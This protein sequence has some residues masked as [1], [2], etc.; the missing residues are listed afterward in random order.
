MKFL[1]APYL[2]IRDEQGNIYRLKSSEKWHNLQILQEPSGKKA[3]VNSEGQS[4]EFEYSR[5]EYSD[6]YLIAY[7]TDRD[8]AYFHLYDTNGNAVKYEK[9]VGNKE[10][11]RGKVYEHVEKWF[12][13]TASDG[14]FFYIKNGKIEHLKKATFITAFDNLNTKFVAIIKL[15]FYG[16]V[17]FEGANP[18][19]DKLERNLKHMFPFETLLN[20]EYVKDYTV[21]IRRFCLGNGMVIKVIVMIN[22]EKRYITYFEVTKNDIYEKYQIHFS[23]ASFM[24]LKHEIVCDWYQDKPE[25]VLCD[26][27]KGKKVLYNLKQCKIL[28]ETQ[29]YA[30]G[31]EMKQYPYIVCFY[32]VKEGQKIYTEVYDA[33]QSKLILN[34]A[35]KRLKFMLIN[36]E[37]QIAW[38]GRTL[39]A[40]SCILT[41]G[42]VE[43]LPRNLRDV[44]AYGEFIVARETKEGVYIVYVYK[45]SDMIE[46]T[47]Q[48]VQK[49]DISI[50]SITA[51]TKDMLIL[52]TLVYGFY[53]S[54]AYYVVCYKGICIKKMYKF[55]GLNYEECRKKWIRIKEKD[56]FIKVPNIGK[57]F[58]D[59]NQKKAY[60]V[61]SIRYWIEKIKVLGI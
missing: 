9:E 2:A 40:K 47:V 11:I 54:R 41:Y 59:Y 30:D 35:V 1:E 24:E 29:G 7:A 27:E 44:K 6:Q 43:Y 18:K 53:F 3:V 21:D 4:T 19:R 12:L 28:F 50:D 16:K 14:S 23:N 42:D 20:I 45:I 39:D 49:R 37:K 60:S 61:F 55:K 34:T 38:T 10:K 56:G 22:S 25:Y 31:M 17:I 33:R 8:G 32:V 5:L 15:T 57:Y 52:A 26:S 13:I 46:K 36:S 51:I 58:I 48:Y